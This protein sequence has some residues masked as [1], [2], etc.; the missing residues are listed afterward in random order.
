MGNAVTLPVQEWKSCP[1]PTGSVSRP[2][3]D[4]VFWK[5][6]GKVGLPSHP[7]PPTR[8]NTALLL[9]CSGPLAHL[10]NERLFRQ[11]LFILNELKVIVS[12]L[13]GAAAF[14]AQLEVR[15]QIPHPFGG[16]G[17]LSFPF[18]GGIAHRCHAE[19]RLAPLAWEAHP[20]L[21]LTLNLASEP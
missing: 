10:H 21:S 20:P 15:S 3:A 16:G 5:A 19:A 11:L 13:P 7:V 9:L 12:W 6:K 8:W 18:L 1:S 14:L 17:V 2:L 4:G